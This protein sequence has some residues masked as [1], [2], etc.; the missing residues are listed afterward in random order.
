MSNFAISS[1]KNNSSHKAR[2]IAKWIVSAVVIGV[3]LIFG[4]N[5]TYHYTKYSSHQERYTYEKIAIGMKSAIEYRMWRCIRALLGLK[6]FALSYPG[7]NNDHFQTFVANIMPD[8]PEIR[9]LQLAPDG[10]VSYLSNLSGN[11]AA[12]GLDLLND[13]R[14]KVTALEAIRLRSEVVAG[15]YTLRQGGLGLVCR[16][17]IF[18]EKDRRESFW[19]FAS[20]VVD[21]LPFLKNSGI[22]NQQDVKFALKNE[23]P[24]EAEPDFFHGKSEIYDQDPVLSRINIP[25]RNWWLAVIPERGWGAYRPW[26]TAI[27]GIV[28]TLAFVAGVSTWLILQQNNLLHLQLDEI[29][30]LRGILPICAEC[31]KVRDQKGGW[32]HIETYI[33]KHTGWSFTHGIC[34]DCLEEFYSDRKL[35]L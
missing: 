20:S 24:K 34:P 33:S 2:S 25:G 17:P 32:N 22:M 30:V 5:F 8:V 35:Y 9:C 7:F 28:C 15:P 13:P 10:K 31:N 29:K 26:S 3:I 12:M 23:S 1:I 18:V 14:E 16:L 19:G 21:L 11:E 27:A 6:A 4:L